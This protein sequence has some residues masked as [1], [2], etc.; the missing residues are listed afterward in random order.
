MAKLA[1]DPEVAWEALQKGWK[2]PLR[3]IE[4]AYHSTDPIVLKRP[5]C[6]G[7]TDEMFG[8]EG[9]HP[10]SWQ[11]K[12]KAICAGCVDRE[13]CL[14]LALRDEGTDWHE[15]RHGIYG[16]ASASM[17]YGLARKFL[18]KVDEPP[19]PEDRGVEDVH[20]ALWGTTHGLAAGTREII[21]AYE[22][23]VVDHEAEGQR[24][25]IK[26]RELGHGPE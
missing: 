11:P 12:A 20:W 24:V 5:E 18:V 23:P 3:I 13:E 22:A 17:R 19:G 26:R 15:F 14:A 2:N 21:D 10:R 7:R 6:L 4:L 9:Q 1:R 25:W 8:E 16:G